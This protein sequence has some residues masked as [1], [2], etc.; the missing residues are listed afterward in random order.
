M[1]KKLAL[2]FAVLGL[3][4]LILYSVSLSNIKIT[5]KSPSY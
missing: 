3:A 5:D 1:K 2:D 4:L